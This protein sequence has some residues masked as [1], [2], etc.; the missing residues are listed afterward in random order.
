MLHH[1]AFDELL[2]ERDGRITTLA[3]PINYTMEGFGF[4]VY[5]QPHRRVVLTTDQTMRGRC[6][7]TICAR[8]T[9]DAISSALKDG[10]EILRVAA[11][12]DDHTVGNLTA[13][14]HS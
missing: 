8:G 12:P 10:Q 7:N 11:S 2:L 3:G 14:Q 6:G 9:I 5:L 4:V 13:E 1:D